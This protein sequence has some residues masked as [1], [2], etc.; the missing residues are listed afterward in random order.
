[1]YVTVSRKEQWHNQ[2]EYVDV[3]S[4]TCETGA[5]ILKLLEVFELV[6]LLIF[7]PNDEDLVPPWQLAKFLSCESGRG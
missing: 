1:M 7:W 3:R 5:E 6:P 2:S 4:L